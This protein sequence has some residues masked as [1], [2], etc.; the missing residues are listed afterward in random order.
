MD[1]MVMRIHGMS[2][3]HCVSAVKNALTGL[4]GVKVERVEV[5]QAAV[6]YDPAVTTPDRIAKA[7]EGEGYPVVVSS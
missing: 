7:V 4:E 5:G 3:G 2:C 6:S 1:R